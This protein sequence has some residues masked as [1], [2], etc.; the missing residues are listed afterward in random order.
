MDSSSE[1]IDIVLFGSGVFLDNKIDEL[2]ELPNARII[3]ICDSNEKMWG[4]KKLGVSVS[5]PDTVMHTKYDYIVIT[6]LHSSEIRKQLLGM[7]IPDVLILTYEMF[8]GMC[9][10]D[11]YDEYNRL[12]EKK[13]DIMIVSPHVDFDGASI[14]AVYAAL[15]L[16]NRGYGV[17][18][19][20][21]SGG[22]AFIEYVSRLGIHI[23]VYPNV[24]FENIDDIKWLPRY[25]Y[26]IFNTY[27]THNCL[28]LNNK[29]NT[30]WWLHESLEA[31][32]YDMKKYE[33]PSRSE[34]EGLKIYCVSDQAKNN[35]CHYF[36]Y[37]QV[38]IME[39]GIPDESGNVDIP[40]CISKGD[41]KIISI[42]GSICEGKGQDV[43]LGALS[44]FH[45]DLIRDCELWIIGGMMQ[46][47]YFDK[48]KDMSDNIKNVTFFHKVAHNEVIQLL[49]CSDVL[50]CPSRQDS[51]PIVV[52]EA[53]MLSKPCVISNVIGTMKY[54]RPG[55]DVVAFSSEDIKDLSQKL[56][57]VLENPDIADNYGRNGR[58]IY[59]HLFNMKSFADRLEKALCCSEQ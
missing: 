8:I 34:I 11:C 5:S 26:K 13:S 45:S 48:I 40:K 16:K 21:P 28:R 56:M 54:V 41:K 27:L 44:E 38:N 33:P 3:G 17:S 2:C 50:V 25:R 37:T 35:F 52:T 51:L 53:M 47:T 29:E 1:K 46:K 23:I 14:A 15:A 18:I 19:I 42:V 10:K 57:Q 9:Y 30:I 43:L 58:N 22:Q 4:K 6:S 36:P 39:Y 31:Y 32:Q 12:N 20:V 59:E 49:K 24:L 7:H 55:E